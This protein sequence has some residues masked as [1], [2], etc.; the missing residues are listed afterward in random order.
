MIFGLS[1]LI[2]RVAFIGKNR[3]ER[4][5]TID[6]LCVVWSVKCR[7]VYY[8]I[9]FSTLELSRKGRGWVDWKLDT[10]CRTPNGVLLR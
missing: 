9:L 7:C 6:A 5:M 2:W 10:V 3:N 4:E 8:I 1:E